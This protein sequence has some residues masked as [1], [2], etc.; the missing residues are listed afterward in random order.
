[1][2]WS[3]VQSTGAEIRKYFTIHSGLVIVISG[4]WIAST[5]SYRPVEAQPEHPEE[6][7]AGLRWRA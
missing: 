7:S 1:M 3:G 2:A 6:G 4:G 5:Y